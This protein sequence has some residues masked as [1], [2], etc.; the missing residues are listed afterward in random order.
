MSTVEIRES[1]LGLALVLCLLALPAIVPL[2]A[3][4]HWG[5]ALAVS[6]VIV[7]IAV[8][9]SSLRVR[10]HEERLTVRFG[11][12]WTVRDVPL[13]A[14]VSLR[15]VSVPALAGVGL[16]LL[17]TGT[18]YSVGPGDAVEFALRD[19]SR[20]FVG[21]SDPDALCE[22]LRAVLPSLDATA[23]RRP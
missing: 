11:G 3:R 23:D 18:L 12:V 9:F 21:A 4:G 20:F 2:A 1:G 13:A 6:I 17:P 19:G 16:R 10:V 8:V 22:R 7:S 14:I 15:R 5:V